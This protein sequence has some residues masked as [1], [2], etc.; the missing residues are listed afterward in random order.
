MRL[1]IVGKPNVGKSTFFR[2]ITASEA[3]IGDYPFTTIDA[4][5]GIGYVT[6]DCPCTRL[7]VACDAST[8]CEDGTRFV[9]VNVSDVAGLV[10]GAAEGKGM[11]NAFLDAVREA[12]AL[13]HILDA[14]GTTDAKG[15]PAEDH[16]VAEDVTFVE[17]EFDAWLHGLLWEDWDATVRALRGA[18]EPPEAFLAE[19]LSGLGITRADLNR[20]LDADVDTMMHWDEAD[21]R[22]LA[23]ALRESAKPIMYAC[24]KMDHPAADGTVERLR[25]EFPGRT[26]VPMSAQAELTLQQAADQG[27]VDYVSGADSF[28]I[29]GDVTA[30]Q[31]EGLDRI[32][33]L[34]D[35][36]GS[37][38]VQEVMRRAVFDL[39]DMIVVYPVEDAAGFTDQHGNVL[40]DAVLLPR[41]STPVDL[42]YAIHSDIGDAYAKAVD[43][44]TGRAVGKDAALEDGQV[45]KIETR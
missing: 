33:D 21:V 15:E 1:G 8:R 14:S 26:F 31:E 35:V 44:E 41:G 6:V 43:A 4:N 32:A 7:E 16:D 5:Q 40:P 34:L 42:A 18:D 45:V 24:N 17:D 36:H 11:G 29:V 37:T 20:V 3:E 27:V 19:R 38:G 10:P 2:C 22:D 13:V 12:H 23:A 39:L 9:P 28:D 30:A 25:A